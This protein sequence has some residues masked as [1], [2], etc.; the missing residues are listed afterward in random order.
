LVTNLNEKNQGKGNK[1]NEKA[2]KQQDLVSSS[3]SQSKG[4]V[5]QSELA[6][7]DYNSAQVKDSENS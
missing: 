7:Q 3:V 5:E 1:K 2:S 6:S 4:N